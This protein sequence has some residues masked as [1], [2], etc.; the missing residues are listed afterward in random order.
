M[1]METITV[2][3]KEQRV[4]LVLDPGLTSPADGEVMEYLHA[5]GLE[6]KRQYREVR[7]EGERLVLYFGHCYLEGHLRA[8]KA[9]A[10]KASV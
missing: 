5:H 3:P 6:P 8:L 9:M 4:L 2:A 10:K 7:E 1:K